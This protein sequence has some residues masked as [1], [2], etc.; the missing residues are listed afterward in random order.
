[1]LFR[2]LIACLLMVGLSGCTD[3]KD[4]TEGNFKKSLQAYLDSEYPKCYFMSEM[5][6]ALDTFEGSR[7]QQRYDAMKQAGL[8]VSS[9]KEA[10]VEGVFLGKQKKSIPVYELTEEGK[11]YFKN[12]VSKTMNGKSVGGFCGGKANIVEIV[13][14]TEPADMWGQ[15][16]SEVV[17]TYTVTDLPEWAKNENILEQFREIKQDVESTQTPLKDKTALVLTN[18]GWTHRKL[19]Q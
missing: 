14:F 1:M 8:L 2:S 13:Q 17:Y 19:L 12:D 7:T 15:K 3:P 6:K 4:A 18:N 11:K 5:P 9:V 10:E 16:L